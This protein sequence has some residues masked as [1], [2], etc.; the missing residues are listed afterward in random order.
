MRD[1]NINE[2]KEEEETITILHKI[3]YTCTHIA[4]E[5][6]HLTFQNTRLRKLFVFFNRGN[7]LPRG[8]KC[9]DYVV[10]QHKD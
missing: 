10:T 4:H 5:N 9:T 6:K 8:L 3:I 2:I 7:I 1:M